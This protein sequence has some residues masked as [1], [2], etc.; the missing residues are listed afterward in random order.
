MRKV[1]AFILALLMST[2][3]VSVTAT[4]KQK[5]VKHGDKITIITPNVMAR[6]CP[7]PNCGQDQHITRIPQGSIL[8][9][10]GMHAVETQFN[11]VTWFEVTF[12][13]KRGWVSIFD[14]DKQ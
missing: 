12:K 6:L 11:T 9:V 2:M 8:T 14:T 5:E 13:G 3:I 10:E 1:S 7:F 4:A